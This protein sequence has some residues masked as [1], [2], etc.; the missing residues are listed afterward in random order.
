MQALP[1]CGGALAGSS[2]LPSLSAKPFQPD[3]PIPDFHMPSD[4]G[5]PDFT[6]LS[7][8]SGTMSSAAVCQVLGRLN[9]HPRVVFELRRQ[10]LNRNGR[11]LHQSG[12]GLV[13]SERHKDQGHDQAY[14]SHPS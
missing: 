13:K 6:N 11:R 9:S 10:D 14:P 12:D 1:G 4:I 2:S 3:R 7:L 8:I 5:N